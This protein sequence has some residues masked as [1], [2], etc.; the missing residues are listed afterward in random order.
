MGAMASQITSLTIVY[1]IVYS[2]ALQR[3]HQ[4]SASLLI[5]EFPTPMSSNAENVSIWWRHH[6][7]NIRNPPITP[8]R[9][10]TGLWGFIIWVIFS[11]YGDVIMNEMASQI[12]SLTIVYS[13]VYSGP[14]QRKNQSSVLLAFVRGIYRWPV[15]SPHKRPVT[16]K[17]FPFDEVIMNSLLLQPMLSTTYRRPELN[18]IILMLLHWN[19]WIY[20]CEYMKAQIGALPYKQ[21]IPQTCLGYNG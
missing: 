6:G 7:L 16:R 5:G 12:T 3:K 13:T 2:G 10:E 15:N 19:W 21:R 20:I 18:M 17:M 11:H 8:T 9:A 1:S 4:C 14:D